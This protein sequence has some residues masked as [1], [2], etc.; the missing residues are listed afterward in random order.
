LDRGDVHE[1]EAARIGL[2]MAGGDAAKPLEQPC[3]ALD[4]VAL[5]VSSRIQRLGLL[6]FACRDYRMRALKAR[7]RPQLIAVTALVDE[8]LLRALRRR[9]QVGGGGYVGRSSGRQMH[10][11]RHSM[12]LRQ[13]MNRGAE[14]NVRLAGGARMALSFMAPA[15][16]RCAWMTVLSII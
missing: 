8:P 15:L 6:E 5:G 3:H 1:A 2:V 10:R 13:H 14:A 4:A 11:H 7:L 12:R 9:Q 16:C